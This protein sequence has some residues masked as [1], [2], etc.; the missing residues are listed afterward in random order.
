[1]KRRKK[2]QAIPSLSATATEEE[3]IQWVQMHD[4]SE[5]LDAGVSEVVEDHEDLERVVEDAQYEGN[6]AQLNMRI[7]PSLKAT[8]QRLARQRTTDATTLARIWL[9]ERIQHECRALSEK[10]NL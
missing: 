5:R 6:T 8:L 3:I 10:K 4:L 7:P 2:T 1:M 9:A